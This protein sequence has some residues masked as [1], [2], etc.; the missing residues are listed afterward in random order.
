MS[1]RHSQWP[2][3]PKYSGEVG[4][5]ISAAVARAGGQK[6]PWPPRSP[7]AIPSWPTTVGVHDY[8]LVSENSNNVLLSY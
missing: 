2:L 4:V 3:H 8:S 1:R 5:Q 7:F 6:L